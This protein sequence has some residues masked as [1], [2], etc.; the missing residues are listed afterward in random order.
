MLT[1]GLHRLFHRNNP[2]ATVLQRFAFPT[3][4]QAGP[5]KESLIHL[6]LG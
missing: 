3:L 5:L 2:L 1:D 4:N 6:A